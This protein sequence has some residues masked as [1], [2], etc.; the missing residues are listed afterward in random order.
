MRKDQI[1]KS[2]LWTA[3]ITM[4]MNTLKPTQKEIE[5]LPQVKTF[6]E[7]TTTPRS[8]SSTQ[9]PN[10][11]QLKMREKPPSNRAI[12]TSMTKMAMMN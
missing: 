8:R 10:R 5:T 9:V 2:T 11:T 7:L 1:K 12:K 3:C 4:M 6:E